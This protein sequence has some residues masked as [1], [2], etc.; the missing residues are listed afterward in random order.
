MAGLLGCVT[1]S[2]LEAPSRSR[3]SWILWPTCVRLD[4]IAEI[5]GAVHWVAIDGHE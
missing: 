3:V 2:V 4:A 5:G 1:S